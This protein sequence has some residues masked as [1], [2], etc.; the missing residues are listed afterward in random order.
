MKTAHRHKVSDPH[1]TNLRMHHLSNPPLL[2][3]SETTLI[4]N[5]EVLYSLK[6][7]F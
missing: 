3:A 6:F 7:S 1:N 5:S 4:L 2:A